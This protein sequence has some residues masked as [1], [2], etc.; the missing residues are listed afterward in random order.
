MRA[1]FDGG[2]IDI[3]HFGHGKEGKDLY[4]GPARTFEL[5]LTAF[6]DAHLIPL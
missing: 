4:D 3:R 5:L 6:Q 1:S 2:Y